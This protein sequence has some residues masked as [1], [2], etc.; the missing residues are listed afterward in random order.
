MM[1]IE[2]GIPRDSVAADSALSAPV[3]CRQRLVRSGLWS[4]G[5]P[6]RGIASSAVHRHRALRVL[7][8][9]SADTISRAPP[10][11]GPDAYPRL[12]ADRL[13]P[14]AVLRLDGGPPASRAEMEVITAGAVATHLTPPTDLLRHLWPAA[15][16]DHRGPASGRPV[17]AF[18]VPSAVE[19]SMAGYDGTTPGWRHRPRSVSCHSAGPTSCW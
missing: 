4:A 12:S 17:V 15:H 14:P 19:T 2:S 5:G 6:A 1:R 9:R 7:G 11:A 10:A 18:S 13:A 16:S 8:A 3:Q